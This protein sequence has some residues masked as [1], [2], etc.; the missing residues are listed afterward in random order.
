MVGLNYSIPPAVND[1]T[2]KIIIIKFLSVT[3]RYHGIRKL[4]SKQTSC[5]QTPLL[6][7]LDF[8]VVK[9]NSFHKKDVSWQKK[10][11]QSTTDIN[12]LR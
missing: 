1:L 8:E 11:F 9:P 6:R 2:M 12:L 4:S 10:G 7:L 5:E 3:S